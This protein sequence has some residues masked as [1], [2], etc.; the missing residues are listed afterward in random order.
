[1]YGKELLDELRNI[2]TLDLAYKAST[3]LE[4]ILWVLICITGTIWAVYFINLQFLSWEESP[5][6]II[7]GKLDSADLKYPAVTIC[8]KFSNKYA[9]AE[10]LGNFIDPNNLPEELL[11]LRQEFFMC[12]TRLWKQK[13]STG[14]KYYKERCIAAEDKNNGCQ[15]TIIQNM[16]GNMGNYYFLT[17]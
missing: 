13:P 17:W 10:R 8:P 1:M 7:Q 6:V 11:I 3:I 14:K 4:K 2:T 5:S 9:I 12:A 16:L 15:V